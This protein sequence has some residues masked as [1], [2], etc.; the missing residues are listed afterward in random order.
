[1][2]GRPRSVAVLGAGTMGAPMAR[3]LLRAGFE[4]GVWDGTPAKVEASV[5]VGSEH[6]STPPQ[7]SR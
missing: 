4:V 6:A 5:A 2:T 3:N 1:M 7:R